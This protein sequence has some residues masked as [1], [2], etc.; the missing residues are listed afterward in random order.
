[1]LGLLRNELRQKY[2]GKR[3]GGSEDR[4]LGVL[5]K[6]SVQR[7]KS[8][9]AACKRAKSERKTEN[10]GQE[11]QRLGVLRG[12]EKSKTR[13]S[14]RGRGLKIENRNYSEGLV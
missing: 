10:R 7:C 6:K 5:G 3:A 12:S 9:Y 11:G 8:V 4:R 13:R 14:Q 2:R 1:M